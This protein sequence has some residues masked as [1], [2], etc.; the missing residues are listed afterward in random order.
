MPFSPETL[1]FPH[2]IQTYKN[3]NIQHKTII[4][5]LHAEYMGF[6]TWFLTDREHKLKMLETRFTRR[7]FG[8]IREDATGGSEKSHRPTEELHNL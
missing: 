5:P 1:I 3:V 6:E 2:A 4:L 8:T 7:I